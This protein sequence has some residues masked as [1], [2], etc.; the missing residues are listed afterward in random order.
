MSTR[1][2]W[3]GKDVRE[4][5]EGGAIRGAR[6]TV[7]S[8][9]R[10]EAKGEGMR[11]AAPGTALYRRLVRFLLPA[12]F[13][14]RYLEELVWV[15]SELSMEARTRNGFRGGLTIWLREMPALLRLTWRVRRGGDVPGAEEPAGRNQALRR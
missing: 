5:T 15:F 2:P 12:H 6:S 3:H 9:A 10:R 11:A 13:R 14:E 1:V 7:H 4:R 8:V